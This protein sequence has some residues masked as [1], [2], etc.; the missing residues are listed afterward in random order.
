MTAINTLAIALDNFIVNASV[1][2]ENSASFVSN[3]MGM[4]A[5]KTHF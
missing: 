4:G 1:P 5:L 2:D 3:K